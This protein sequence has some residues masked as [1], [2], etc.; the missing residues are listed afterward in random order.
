MRMHNFMKIFKILFLIFISFFSVSFSQSDKKILAKKINEEIILDGEMTED[1]WIKAQAVSNFFQY[2]PRDSVSAE[3][4]T[5][6]R[7]AYDDKF[8][9]ILAKMEDISDK[10]FI[11]GDLKRDFF[12]GVTDYI[13]FTFDTF[14]KQMDIILGYLHIIFKERLYYQVE[15]KEI[16]PWEEGEEVE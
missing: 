10:K 3:L 1:F 8:L 4:D 12:G 16:F 9:Y 6:F 11:L 15:E 13:S 7:I 14:L 2:R 5:E